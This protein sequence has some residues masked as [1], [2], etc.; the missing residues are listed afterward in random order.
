MTCAAPS[1]AWP[2][3]AALELGI[4]KVPVILLLHEAGQLRL[5]VLPYN[6]LARDA[7][8]TSALQQAS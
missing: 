7:A 8:L 1:L 5:Y 3:L 4:A 6:C 2:D